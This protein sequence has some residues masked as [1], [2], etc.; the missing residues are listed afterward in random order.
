M[1]TTREDKLDEMLAQRALDQ[2]TNTIDILELGYTMLRCTHASH[3]L[4]GQL[5]S[6]IEAA[7]VELDLG[8][9]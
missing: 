1:A 3:T 8:D 7:R 6:L 9:D 2:C 5:Q 4:L